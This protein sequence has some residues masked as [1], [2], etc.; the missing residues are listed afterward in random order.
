MAAAPNNAHRADSSLLAAAF[1]NAPLAADSVAFLPVDAQRLGLGNDGD[2]VRLHRADGTPIAEVPYS[3]DWHTPSLEDTKGTSLER[4]SPTGSATAPD[5]W[6]SSTAPTGG[7]PGRRNEVSLAPPDNA[8]ERG[9]QVEPSPFSLQRDGATRIRYRLNDV[10]N[11]VRAR[12]FDARGRKVRTLE[13]ARLTGRTGELVWNGRND[14]GNRVRIGVYVVLFEAV[15]ANAGTVARFK[16]PV[17]VA[18]PLN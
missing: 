9:L 12:I 6:T 5:N 14:D 1:P 11:L 18:R 7:T 2:R 13:D 17:V 8:S 10:P 16:A 4:I 15:R 3:P